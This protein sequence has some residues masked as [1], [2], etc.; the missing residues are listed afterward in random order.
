MTE[1][2]P[3]PKAPCWASAPF[4]WEL[5]PVP[6]H[7]L[8]IYGTLF[9]FVGLGYFFSSLSLCV[10]FHPR[11]A[12][13]SGLLN[14]LSLTRGPSNNGFQPNA[15]LLPCRRHRPALESGQSSPRTPGTPIIDPLQFTSHV[16]P[17]PSD[18]TPIPRGCRFVLCM[19]WC[20]FSFFFPPF[21]CELS[22]LCT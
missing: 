22:P 10:L 6:S 20:F 2:E 19:V 1:F 8:T 15:N 16:T 5:P 9:H 4:H 14:Q 7:G 3:P 17:S 13:S 12:A 18:S 11:A 21:S